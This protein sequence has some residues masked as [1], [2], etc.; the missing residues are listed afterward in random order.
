LCACNLAIDLRQAGEVAEADEL[1]SHAVERLS[2][3]L[4]PES[5]EKDAAATGKRH[6]FDIEPPQL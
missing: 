3:L 6:N 4:G 1:V 2:A 5:P